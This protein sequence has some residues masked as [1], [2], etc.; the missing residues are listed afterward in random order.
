MIYRI[1]ISGSPDWHR[2]NYFKEKNP[3]AF[4]CSS[5][6]AKAGQFSFTLSEWYTPEIA[7]CRI[8]GLSTETIE[9]TGELEGE[10]V[11]LFF[12]GKGK[13][14]LEDKNNLLAEMPAFSNSLFYRKADR[15]IYQ[16]EKDDP[17]ECL[18]VFL[19]PDYIHKKARQYPEVFASL[20]QRISRQD[21]FELNKNHLRSTPEI[22]RLLEQVQQAEEM[23]A[24]SSCYLEMK[25]N[26]LLL[27]QVKQS[28]Q[29]QCALCS[30]FVH[31]RE[32]IDEARKILEKGYRNPP[33]IRELSLQVGMCETMLKAGFKSF[34]GT[35]VFGYS[36]D[37]RMSKALK[38]LKEGRL[39]ISEISE[40]T[41]Y[42]YQSHFTTAF[43]RKFGFTPREC[44]KRVRSDFYM[45]ESI[46]EY[47]L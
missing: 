40:E 33:G 13:A 9:I 25:V 5:K 20:S 43:K 17:D 18:I 34:L 47:G 24:M 27:L 16:P 10:A 19:D 28:R 29:Q 35:T 22:N 38:L 7:V 42:G 15:I 2:M 39:S 6:T 32:Q 31:Y 37:F 4:T 23:G 26:E 1:H 30:C 45:S 41:G 11:F 36:F 12:T 46:A 44:R 14:V 21:S 8:R 3:V